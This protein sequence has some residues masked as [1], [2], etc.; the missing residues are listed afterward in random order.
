MQES[1]HQRVSAEVKSAMKARDKERLAALRLIM[2]EFK[3]VEVDE[4]IE[5]D[6]TRI[7]VILDKMTKQRKDSY[8]Q[9]KDA[10]R[11]DLADTEAREIAII[12]EFLPAKMDDA[13][14]SGLVTAAIEQS[15]AGSMQDMGKVMALL[16]PQ[17]QGKADMGAVS[18][19]VKQKLAS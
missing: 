7:L 10:G 16:K 5:L 4:R 18:G 19:M 15:G 2:S 6:D 8:R 9:Y 13:E 12:E 1:I 17:V 11:D 3:R 14:L